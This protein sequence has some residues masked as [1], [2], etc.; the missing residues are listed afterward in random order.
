MTAITADDYKQAELVVM[1]RDAR[2][3]WRTHAKVAVFGVLVLLFAGLIFSSLV[4]YGAV[5]L[6]WLA[7]LAIHYLVAIRWFDRSRAEFQGRVEFVAQRRRLEHA[8]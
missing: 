4:T 5:A 6:L 2:R 7:A 1:R 8:A 3:H